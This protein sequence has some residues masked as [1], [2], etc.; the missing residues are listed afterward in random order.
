MFKVPLWI[1]CP[2]TSMAHNP[3]MPRPRAT[4][5][6][7][8]KTL[9]QPYYPPGIALA[10]TRS[11]ANRALANQHKKPKSKANHTKTINI[12]N[13]GNTIPKNNTKIMQEQV[14]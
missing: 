1:F 12:L 7:P 11:T 2:I 3:T 8:N 5:A 14:T 6:S 10:A 4:Q 13:E 9:S